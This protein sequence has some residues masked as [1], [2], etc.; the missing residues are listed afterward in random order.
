MLINFIL[1]LRTLITLFL[2]LE[3]IHSKL[4][5]KYIKTKLLIIDF[6]LQ[7]LYYYSF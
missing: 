7:K 2:I 1:N 5:L 4:K 6:S 3:I